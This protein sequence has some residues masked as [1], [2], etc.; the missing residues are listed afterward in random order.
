MTFSAFVHRS[1]LYMMYVKTKKHTVYVINAGFL[2]A[3]HIYIA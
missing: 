2:M 1:L 3:H